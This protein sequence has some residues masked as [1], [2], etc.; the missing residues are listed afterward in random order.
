[1]SS[2]LPEWTARGSR[3][4]HSDIKSKKCHETDNLDYDSMYHYLRSMLELRLRRGIIPFGDRFRHARTVDFSSH[5]VISL[6]IYEEIDIVLRLCAHP[7]VYLRGCKPG[8]L[9]V[10]SYGS[11][12]IWYLLFLTNAGTEFTEQ[13]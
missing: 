13:P 8:L 3:V 2:F 1:M 9:D 7:D 5:I 6:L 12:I 4:G 10:S 11:H